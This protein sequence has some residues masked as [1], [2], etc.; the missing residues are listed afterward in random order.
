MLARE[1]ANNRVGGD[2]RM[3]Q[4][5]RAGNSTGPHQGQPVLVA[6]EVLEQAK[7]AMIMMHGRGASAEDILSLTA[8]IHQSGFIYLAPQAAGYS[9]YP[10]S[11]LASISAEYDDSVFDSRVVIQTR[12]SGWCGAGGNS[13]R[14][15][16]LG[17][18]VPP[19]ST[20]PIMPALR[21]SLPCS[22]RSNTAAIRPG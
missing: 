18:T 3:E 17:R 11:F 14:I 4:H 8:E 9:W 19:V 5:H 10:N 7:A 12:S 20:M 6:G 21:M 13:T 2:L 16:L 1:I 22:S 15:R